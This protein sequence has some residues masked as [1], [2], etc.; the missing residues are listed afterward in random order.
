VDETLQRLN[1]VIVGDN[2]DLRRAIETEDIPFLQRL[3][4]LGKKTATKLIFELKGKLPS[5]G[6]SA[7]AGPPDVMEDA[8]SALLNLGY[9]KGPAE[10]ALKKVKP[11]GKLES[12]ITQA[13]KILSPA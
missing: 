7:S 4:G 1:A 2:E 11:D 12:I 6:A 8:L 13:L 3:P 10:E 9:K 5:A